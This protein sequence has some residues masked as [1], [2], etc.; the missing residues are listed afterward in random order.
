MTDAERLHTCAAPLIA[1]YE[2]HGRDLPWRQTDNPYFILVS[3]VMLQQTR[4]EAVRG[5]YSRF[6]EEFPT[7]RLL[8]EASEDRLLKR[9]EGLGYYS[10][11][12]NLQKAARIIDQ[13]G[14]PH[15]LEGLL[16]LP[17]V[18]P[19][20]ASAVGSICFSLPA[21][22]V[23]GNVL[24]LVSRITG[25]ETPLSDR[26]KKRYT[27]LLSP[28]YAECD[29]HMLTQSLMELGATLCGPN[30]SPDCEQC[31]VISYC[32]GHDRGIADKLPV[33]PPKKERR[34]EQK[35]VFI[36]RCGSALA[37]SKREERGLLSGMYELPNTKGLLSE[38]EA[39]E[40]VAGL[41]VK[42]LN[43][44]YTIARSHVFTHVEWEMRGIAF[45]CANSHPSFIW[46]APEE[47]REHYALPTAFRQFL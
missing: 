38:A 44:Q 33:R 29:P 19:Y 5:Y 21:P 41:G 25:D 45:A 4:V 9:W 27:A 1:W 23:D 28:I 34:K 36:L 2:N 35:T 6:L 12:R 30:G 47:L 3:E 24:R 17:G 37:L 32:A 13:N 15:T 26:V 10:R 7:V 22:A 31:P 39:A 14:F 42:P 40:Y 20:T 46:A 11:A 43:L 8:A 18:G 16:S